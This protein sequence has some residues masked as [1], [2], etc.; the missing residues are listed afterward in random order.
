MS[1]PYRV[2]LSEDPQPGHE[3]RD[4][5]GA[6][7]DSSLQADQV[8]CA[9]SEGQPEVTR[10]QSLE[11]ERLGEVD[12]R[13]HGLDLGHSCALRVHRQVVAEGGADQREKDR[14]EQP[15]ADLQ[16]EPLEALHDADAGWVRRG[17]PG[18]GSSR[19]PP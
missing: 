19:A 6:V 7:D 5:A 3:V 12:S 14:Q 11:G 10:H 9:L 1:Q 16:V 8:P 15:Q 18:T 2:E 4:D 17:Y 13:E